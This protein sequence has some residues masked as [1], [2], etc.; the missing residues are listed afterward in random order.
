[1]NIM[2]SYVSEC[3]HRERDS[4]EGLSALK[5]DAGLAAGS[6]PLKKRP[7]KE[8]RFQDPCPRG[9]SECSRCAYT[10]LTNRQGQVSHTIVEHRR[11]DGSFIKCTIDFPPP[12]A[13]HPD[14]SDPIPLDQN[15]PESLYQH[16]AKVLSEALCTY[17]DIVPVRTTPEAGPP[18]T[19][20]VGDLQDLHNPP[21]VDPNAGDD[22]RR[23]AVASQIAEVKESL[24]ERFPKK[25]VRKSFKAISQLALLIVGLRYDTTL[26]SVVTRCIQFLDALLDDGIIL[27]IHDLLVN[28]VKDVELP[29]LFSGKSVQECFD[30]ENSVC[31][32]E[33]MS[34]T[35][36]T[37]WDTLKK[38]IFTKHLS[39]V[40]GT[41]LA[42][43]TCKLQ[44]VEFNHPL[45][46]AIMKH[47]NE[48]KIDGVDFVDHV[49]KLYNWVS[50]VGLACF[51]QKSLKPLTLN[52]G[53]IAKCHDVYYAVNQWYIDV[54]RSGKATAEE[55]QE[56]YVK[57]ETAYRTLTD[58]CKIDRDKFSTLHASS[59]INQVSVLYNDIKDWVL[60]VDAV[61]VPRAVHIFGP[62]KCGKSMIMKDIHIQHCVAR[63]VPYREGD[64]AIL[65]IMAKYFDELSNSTQCISINEMS[66]V[67]EAYAKTLEGALQAALGLVDSSPYNPDQSRLEDKARVKMQHFSVVSTANEEEPLK[68]V[69]KT[70]GAWARRYTIIYMRMRPE[71][72]DQNDMFDMDKLDGTNDYHLFDVYDIVYLGTRKT[73]QYFTWQ[74][75]DSR[76]MRT[77]E[78]F[79]LLRHLA[80]RHFE[81]QDHLEELR[82][83]EDNVGCLVCKRLK[84]FCSCSQGEDD[85][86]GSIYH[87]GKTDSSVVSNLKAEQ[88]CSARS[89]VGP[90]S[91]P[92]D[93]QPGNDY[94]SFCGE[95]KPEEPKPKAQKTWAPKGR[96]K[97]VRI[98][99]STPEA[100]T[101]AGSFMSMFFGLV[102][103]SVASWINPFIKLKWL[104]SIDSATTEALREDLLEE[105]KYFPDK[106]GST[107]LS[108]IP[109]EWLYRQDGSPSFL[110]KAKDRF[111]RLVAAEKQIFLPLRVLLK[112]SFSISVLIFVIL[113]GLV[114]LLDYLG[115]ERHTW[116]FAES[117]TYT[118][119]RWG[120][121]PLYPEYSDHVMANREL[122]AKQ[123]IYTLAHLEWQDYYVDLYFF[124]RLLGKLFIYWRYDEE[125]TTMILVQKMAAWW[126]FPTMMSS[127]YFVLFFLWM[128]MKRALGFHARYRD[129]QKRTAHDPE[130][131]MALYNKIRRH[132]DEFNPYVPTMIGLLGVIMTGATLWYSRSTPEGG[133]T[134]NEKDAKQWDSFNLFNRLIPKGSV[135]NSVTTSD[136][137][138]RLKKAMCTVDVTI[139]GEP[140]R[141]IGVYVKTGLLMVPHHLF[142]PN[143]LGD[144]VQDVTDVYINCNG[145]KSKVR[146]YRESLIKMNGKDCVIL[147]VPRAPKM[148]HDVMELLP[149]QSGSDCHSAT[150]VHMREDPESVNARYTDRVDCGGTNCGVGV[151]YRSKHTQRGYCGT[152][153]IHKGVVLGFHI[154]GEDSMFSGRIGYAQEIKR[155]D[156][157]DYLDRLKSDPDFIST[158][159]AGTPPTT[160]LDYKLITGPGPHPKT[161]VFAALPDYNSIRIVGHNLDLVR[162]RSRVRKSLISDTLKE[163]TGRPNV[164]KAPDMKAPWKHHNKAL[165]HVAEGAWEVPPSALRW[166]FDDYLSDILKRLSVYKQQH[167]EL[168]RVLT[169]EEMINGVPEGIYMKMVNMKTSIGPVGKGSGSKRDSDIFEPIPNR[170]DFDNIRYKLSEKAFVYFEEMKDY[171]RKGVKY[172]VWTRTCLKDEVVDEDSEKV[173]IF[174]ILECI[175]A[176]MVRQYY[177]P[178][179]EFI[180]RNPTLCEC[181]VGINCAGPEWEQ[182]MQYVQ[183][184]ATDE[185]MVDWDYSKYDLKR[186][187]DVTIASMNVMRRIAEYMEYSEESLAIM[188]GIADELRNPTIDWNGTIITCFLWSSGNSMT[189]YGNSIENSLHNRISFYVNGV[190]KLGLNSFLSLGSFRENERIITYGDDGQSG[191]KPE[192]RS[193]CNFPAKESYFA[194]INMKITDAAKSDDPADEVHRDLID[195]LK[196][197]SVYHDKLNCRVGALA[198]TSIDKM[199]HMVSGKGELEDLAVNAIIT[200]LLESFLHG[201]EVYSRYRSDLQQVAYAHDIWTEYLDYDYDTL[202]DRWKN[203]YE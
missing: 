134:R 37:V 51:Q 87:V 21:V 161:Q 38:G 64:H 130:M 190:S 20:N 13:N 138:S 52:S 56:N 23:S 145:F 41:A 136:T 9:I 77:R 85:E 27:S 22:E 194:S 135:D 2:S 197:K 129:L 140:V 183:E 169:H 19:I 89:T 177:L 168:C 25:L 58:L 96:R 175:F 144:K 172:G 18:T 73:R 102:M 116:E 141:V 154:S 5:H 6:P 203:H 147:K 166:A 181:A 97:K 50:S 55:R 139:A 53:A 72:A 59:L 110:G 39:Y 48:E 35:A 104:W 202:I 200:M 83:K 79:E 75:E 47:A 109:P 88:V 125:V 132:V 78:M 99:K 29:E 153:V 131:Q 67:K 34:D 128:W 117:Y 14:F 196:R 167:P 45:H 182:A 16:T 122:Y 106:I 146:I 1:M 193:L 124:Q 93:Y 12:D 115:F 24:L 61:K 31:T 114:F 112:R 191:S 163:V 189:V 188:D 201:P 36:Q 46:D 100:G 160:R 179:A 42:F 81:H 149:V 171:F 180:S 103:D 118:V 44:R 68:H 3:N 80:V 184:L 33:T 101:F 195:F 121:I 178:I 162:Y 49:L 26:E 192:V 60:K 91:C 187:Q 137:I 157:E 43:F 107:A 143:Q 86:T 164:W 11:N 119:E 176:L 108:Y 174:Y 133:I 120:W 159:E 155:T 198:L 98:P 62:P 15:P 156:V 40:V 95:K 123:G 71:Y 142:K 113:T 66:A 165:M 84:H 4:A 126:H 17:E 63:G 170:E 74:G 57:I 185:K 8:V 92:C 32:P 94:C 82:Q 158:P 70:P 127:A 199:G 7:K 76:N 30:L 173:R 10:F 150:I 111:I 65:N 69:A 152:P 90:H 151:S 148:R 186:S 54:R 105:L 28:Y